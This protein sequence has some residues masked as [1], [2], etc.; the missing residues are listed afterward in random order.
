MA[1]GMDYRRRKTTIANLIGRFWDVE[2]GEVCIGGVN[3]KDIPVEDLNNTVSTVFQD[4]FLFFDT[5]EENIRMGNTKARDWNIDT[6]K[7]AVL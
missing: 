4:V 7:E 1:A 3:I 2:T 5:I 6:D